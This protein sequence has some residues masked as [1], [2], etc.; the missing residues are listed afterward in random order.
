MSVFVAFPPVSHTHEK[1]CGEGKPRTACR[2]QPRDGGSWWKVASAFVVLLSAVQP[3]LAASG[4]SG[5]QKEKVPEP[6]G[7]TVSYTTRIEPT[8]NADVDA[9]LTSSSDL[10]N[11][12]KLHAVGPFALAG[13]IRNEYSR[14]NTALESFG[15]YDGTITITMD[16]PKNAQVPPQSKMEGQ[17]I[18]LPLWL[19]S[20]PSGQTLA[21]RIT[22]KTGPLYHVGSVKLVEPTTKKPVILSESQQKAFGMKTGVPAVATTVL[23][24]ANQLNDTLREEGHPLAKVDVPT[25]WLQPTSRTLDL[26]YPVT[27]GPKADIG[28]ITLNGLEYTNPKFVRKRLMIAP[29]QL[30]Q[31]SR[32]EDAR[33]DLASLGIFSTVGVKDAPRLA[34][35]GSMPL[36]FSFGEAKRHTVGAEVGYSTDLGGRV[37]ASWTHHNLFGNAERLKLTALVTGVGG[38]AQQGLGYDV[39][40]DLF[41]PD[42]P[43]RRQ[44]A[45]F[46]VEGIRQL[47]YSYR[48]T[49]IILRAGIVRQ[50]SKRW[51][52]SYGVA[53]EQ[54]TIEQF[55]VTRDY[56]LIFAPISA[57]YDSTDLPS[58]LDPATHGARFSLS[59]TP[60]ASFNHGTRFFALLQAN[61]STYF[62]LARLGLT[63]PGRSVFAFRGIVG[64][65][66]GASTYD[67]PPDQRLYGG[68]TATIRGFRYQGVGP[69]F[70][71]SKYAIGGT[72]LDAGTV[73]FRQRFF[74][75]WGAA[76]FMDAG[77]VGSGSAPFT[78]TV[79]V[80]AGAGARYFTPIGPVRIDIAVPL[81]RQPRGDKWELYIG[82]GETF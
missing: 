41:K 20:M 7:P 6:V 67:I 44:N 77:Q 43:G 60:S 40:A 56:S 10:L 14:L 4:D 50:I 19:A 8:G 81:N 71:N 27:I 58:P 2:R 53:A 13:R 26:M 46:R 5:K 79:R 34:P 29:G 82:L 59:V 70:P 63:Q 11:L 24:A 36:A 35:D 61:A 57:N 69:Q 16:R 32:I 39:Y 15:F 12:Q 76:A 38:T 25:A 62:D 30:Y 42:F 74:K 9:A 3:S 28:E 75:S 66:Q 49:A 52:V 17:D 73:E 80:G 78:G 72:S 22:A 65:V 64:S 51:N 21:I 54:E 47:F 45:S 55:G 18:G 33:Q 68:G 31:P 1:K 48:Q 23:Q 37:G